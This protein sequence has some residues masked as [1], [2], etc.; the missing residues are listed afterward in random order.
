M[1]D[2][3]GAAVRLVGTMQEIPATVVTE[4]RMRQQQGALLAL[5]SNERAD[6]VSLDDRLAR[7]TQVAG[8]TLDV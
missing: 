4:R 1:R 6:K 8:T 7:I 3:S 5:V 2:S